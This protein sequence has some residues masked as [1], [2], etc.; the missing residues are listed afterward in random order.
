MPFRLSVHRNLPD[1]AVV[2][3]E[4][5]VLCAVLLRDDVAVLDTESDNEPTRTMHVLST[6]RTVLKNDGCNAPQWQ[7]FEGLKLIHISHRRS[8]YYYV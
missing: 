4:V 5:C 2:S 6:R 7:Q 1:D 8:S 3:V